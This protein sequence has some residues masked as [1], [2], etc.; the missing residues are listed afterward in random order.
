MAS[1]AEGSHSRRKKRETTPSSAA[2]PTS[3]A[4]ERL[5]YISYT[6]CGGGQVYIRFPF[7]PWQALGLTSNSA[8]RD[9]VKM[10]F[11]NKITQPQRQNRALASLANHILTS[12]EPRYQRLPGSDLYTIR[13]RDHFTIAAYGNTEELRALIGRNKSLVKE[14]D[15]HGRTLLYL[16][17]KSGFYDMVKMLLQKGADINKI[18]RDGSTSLHAAAFFGHP[19]VVGLLLE[20]GAQSDIKNKWGQTALQESHSTTIANLITNAS[21]DFIFSL[22][23]KLTAEQLVSE[24][25]PIEFKGKVIAKELIR[26]PNTLDPKTRRGLNTILKTWEMTWHGTQFEHIESIL[27]NGLLPAGTRGIKPPDNHFKL[28]ET[29]FGIKNWAAAIFLSPSILYSA[30]AAYSGRVM[31]NK[32]QWSILF[33]VYCHPGSYKSYDPTV[34]SYEGMDG[35]PDLPEYRVPVEGDDKEVILRVE[36]ERSV[37]VRSLIFIRTSVLENQELNFKDTVKIFKE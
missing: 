18:Q 22:K 29:F 4:D 33:K 34:L 32:E 37:V 11:R 3:R 36:S 25:R 28:G 14:S 30:H 12:T 6:A 10:A 13:S 17:C 19:L 16:A 5:T 24:M 27:A 2:K 31:S 26:S 20:Y 23:T 1:R 21:S 7:N 35:E 15:E 8:S 9:A